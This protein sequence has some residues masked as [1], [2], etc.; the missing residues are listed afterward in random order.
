MYLKVSPKNVPYIEFNDKNFLIFSV[1]SEDPERGFK[2][3][4]FN[5]HITKHIKSPASKK[6]GAKQQ[7]IRINDRTDFITDTKLT[8][9]PR[10][11]STKHPH[12]SKVTINLLKKLFKKYTDSK[13]YIA[14]SKLSDL[15]KDLLDIVEEVESD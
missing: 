6:K 7:Y 9:I 13:G 11:V 12:L 5:G 4:V 10:E 8:K 15:S 1:M 3:L 14:R 2:K